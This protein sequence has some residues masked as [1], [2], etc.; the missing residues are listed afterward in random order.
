M[1]SSDIKGSIPSWER[2]RG[3]SKFIG[4]ILG[5][6]MTFFKNLLC[7]VSAKPLNK[8]SR[9]QNQFAGQ[10]CYIFGDGVSLKWFDLQNF[11]DRVSF[12]FSMI[13]YHP[14]F[15]CLDARFLFLVEPYWF[16]PKFFTD[17]VIADG[18][19]PIISSDYRKRFL[20]QY[21]DK[22]FILNLSNYPVVAQIFIR[23]KV[24][25]TDASS[26]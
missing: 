3:R 1:S 9:F 19:M 24:N 5:D 23:A 22:N 6:L 8:I 13:P 14:Q 12:A 4:K 15:N 7:N 10:K 20:E 2:W 16:Y 11:S 18:S 25:L 17:L 21:P 26:F